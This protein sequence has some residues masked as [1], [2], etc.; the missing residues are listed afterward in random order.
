MIIERRIG[1]CT[2]RIDRDLCVGFGDCVDA[3]PTLF[4]LDDDGVARFVDAAA[5]A[6]APAAPA[7]TAADEAAAIAACHACPV[8][9]LTAFDADGRQLAP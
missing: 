6:A 9:A 7:A 5:L 4:A 2:V 3:A 8:D 1:R